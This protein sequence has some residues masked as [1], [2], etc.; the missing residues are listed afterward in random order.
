MQLVNKN[1]KDP[2]I[3]IAKRSDVPFWGKVKVRAICIGSA[4]VISL[5]FIWIVSGKN[6]FPVVNY[7][8]LGSFENKAK[9][10]GM[11]QDTILLLG[12]A[13]ALAPAYKMKFWNIGAQGQILMGAL[14][15]SI[16]MIYCE[17]LPNFLLIILMLIGALVG[18]ALWGFI[19]AFFKAKW[20]TNETLFTLMMNYIAIQIVNFCTENWRGSQS[21]FGTINGITQKGWFP[22]LGNNVV[23]PMIII[24]L[25]TVA[26]FIYMNKFKHGYEINVLG[27]SRNTAKYIGVNVKWVTIRTL[28]LSGAI[29]GLLGFF[30]VSCLNHSISSSTSG[31]NGFTGIIVCWLGQFNPIY[32]IFYAFILTF[33]YKGANKLKN[34]NYSSNLNDYS[35]EFIILVIILS[36]LLAEFFI[37]YRLIFNFPTK[38]KL[39]LEKTNPANGGK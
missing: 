7:F 21:S 33:L 32:M 34:S 36:I 27:E 31:S 4:L 15:A 29:C 11:V 19:P 37:N 38:K 20:K 16:I 23:F 22:T 17:A 10:W 35:S 26:M 25:L 9:F 8:F 24:L 14:F 1:K 12:V 5:L 6:P 3:R 2:L 18:G 28:L 13:V 39:E 30:Y